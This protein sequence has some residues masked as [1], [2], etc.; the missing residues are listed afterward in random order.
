MTFK[1][2]RPALAIALALTLAACGGK[3]SFTVGGTVSGLKYNGLVLTS[4]GMDLSV[5]PGTPTASG[6]LPTVSFAFPNSISYGD[7][8]EVSV[9]ANSQPAHQ[10]CIVGAFTDENLKTHGGAMDTAGR[11]STIDVG[12]LCSVNAYTIGGTIKG[13][14]TAGLQLTNGSNPATIVA[15]PTGSDIPFTFTSPVPYAA[16]YGVT[17][18]TQPTDAF[19]TVSPSGTGVMGDA[20]VADIVVT[21]ASTKSN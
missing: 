7:V 12:V 10:T 18:L 13:L 14:T 3:A 21:C 4:N 15:T 5:A 11:L 6:A 17:V 20:A 1:F 19:C 2:M 9:K 16:T 8:Y